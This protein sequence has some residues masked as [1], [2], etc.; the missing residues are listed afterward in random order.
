MAS[1]AIVNLTLVFRIFAL[2]L[3]GG[4]IVV[5]VTDTVKFTDG[6]KTTF[7]DVITYRYVL[8]TAAIGGAYSLLQLPCAIY[9]AFK[10]KRLIRGQFLPEFDFY[11]DKMVSF[12]LA[13]G[14]GAVFAVTYELKSFVNDFVETLLSLGFE[15]TVGFKSGTDKFLNRIYIAAG[16]LL[17]AL[18]CMAL[19]SVL[20]SINRTTSSGFFR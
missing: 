19:L 16:L 8:A 9:S 13:S 7:K 12:V 1:K 10:Q 17:G 18:V 2:L 6:S 14:V 11:G 20:S 15:D 3:S 4:C 5:L